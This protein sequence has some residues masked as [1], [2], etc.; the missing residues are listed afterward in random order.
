[1]PTTPD[2]PAESILGP[3]TPIRCTEPGCHW[4]CHGVPDKYADSR[5]RIVREHLAA[6]HAPTPESPDRPADQLRAAADRARELGDTLHTELGN[7]L[8]ATAHR[9]DASTHPDWQWAVVEPSALAVARQLLG[10]STGEDDESCGRFVPD[11]PRAPGLCASCGDAK[12]WHSLLATAAEPSVDRR[13]RYEEALAPNALNVDAA[14]TAAMAVAD[15]E[16]AAAAP[17]A[18]ADRGATRDR[19]R[20]AI[21]EASGFTWLPDELMEPDEYGEHADAVLAVLDAPADRAAVL[22]EAADALAAEYQRR[23]APGIDRWNPLRV[24]GLAAGEA[25]LRRLAGEAAAGAHHP[26]QALRVRISELAG[27]WRLGVDEGDL[28]PGWA[29]AAA[30]LLA[31]V[32]NPH[33]THTEVGL[34]HP[35]TTGRAPAVPAAPEETR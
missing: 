26:E 25:I 28:S 29:S 33:I 15:S 23:T 19:I 4:A 22:A 24:R 2:R 34:D 30:A 17:P 12:G 7:W 18:P 14:V 10:T 9:L 32:D 21:C 5:A 11:T 8:E 20:Q 3:I 13:A 35:A 27:S 31:V 16:I 6:E 1:M